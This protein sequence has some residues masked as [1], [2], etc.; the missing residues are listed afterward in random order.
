MTTPTREQVVQCK[1]ENCN[2]TDGTNHS[3]ECLFEHFVSYRGLNPYEQRVRGDIKA[4]YFDGYDSARADL[5]ATIAEQ[6]TEISKLIAAVADHVTVRAEQ[7]QQLAAEQAY[8]EQLR[9]A[10]EQYSCLKCGSVGWLWGDELDDASEDTRAD[11]MT[12]YQCDGL[13]CKALAL[14]HDTTALQEYGSKMV[15]P[16]KKDADRYRWLRDRLFGAD[17]DWNESGTCALVFEWPKS[18]PVGGNCDMNIDAAMKEN[19][20]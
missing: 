5:E 4:A 11:T 7:R 13:T 18:V 3:V 15:E 9:E 10:L 8:A 16:Y 2:S 1:G 14:N 12:K 17:F 6:A 20:K 19:S